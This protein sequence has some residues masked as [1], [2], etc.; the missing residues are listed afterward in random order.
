MQSTPNDIIL[1]SNNK[2]LILIFR[3]YLKSARFDYTRFFWKVLPFFIT[4]ISS[5]N[6]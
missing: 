4:K 6:I 3:T 1:Y 5:I 2:I